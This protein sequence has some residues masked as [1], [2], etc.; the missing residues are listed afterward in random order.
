MENQKVM[1]GVVNANPGT[2]TQL[3]NGK[4]FIG[5]RSPQFGNKAVSSQVPNAYENNEQKQEVRPEPESDPEKSADELQCIACGSDV[6]SSDAYC[7]SCG[8]DQNRGDLSA[9][10]GVKLGEDDLSEYLFKGYLVKEVPLIKGHKAL[11]KTLTP[12]ESNKVEETV[13]SLFKDKD[14]TNDQWMNTRV[15]SYLSYGWIKFDGTSLGETPEDR[16]EHLNK[17]VGVHLVDL[18]S[19]KWNLLN[20]AVSSML[21]EP[22]IIK[23]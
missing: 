13:L 3:P 5:G 19:K 18:A 9:A 11:F 17:S 8:A 7:S 15:I 10:L 16:M 2:P 23:N 4:H 6:K 12:V 20:R 14:P 1:P 21:E 22:N